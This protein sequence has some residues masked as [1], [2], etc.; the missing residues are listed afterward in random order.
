MYVYPQYT[1]L[2][3]TSELGK[4][5]K[6][7][8]KNRKLDFYEK[9]TNYFFVDVETIYPG[10]QVSDLNCVEQ[11]AHDGVR[12][13]YIYKTENRNPTHPIVLGVMSVVGYGS[14]LWKPTIFLGSSGN[15]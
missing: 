13:T 11:C 6:K 7:L 4:F 14:K 1:N 9:K 2:A 15:L 8:E 3:W 10:I 12:H 5:F